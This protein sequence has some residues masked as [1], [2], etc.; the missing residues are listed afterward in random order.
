MLEIIPSKEFRGS[1][2]EKDLGILFPDKTVQV[3]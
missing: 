3:D 1:K 2:V